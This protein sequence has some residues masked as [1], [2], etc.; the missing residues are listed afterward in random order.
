V[1]NIFVGN[2]SF[3]TTEDGLRSTFEHF[4]EVLKVNLVADRDTGRMRGFAFVE[5]ANAE[6]A[7]RAIAELNGKTVDGRALTVNEARSKGDRNSGG[8][9]GFRQDFG[10]RERR[11]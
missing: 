1:K 6:E 5:M 10:G 11:W 9:N 2:L 3:Q 8:R 4:G 7:D